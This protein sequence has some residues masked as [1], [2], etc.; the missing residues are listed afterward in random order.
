MVCGKEFYGTAEYICVKFG[1]GDAERLVP[2]VKC[3][4]QSHGD[5]FKEPGLDRQK[6][7]VTGKDAVLAEQLATGRLLLPSNLMGI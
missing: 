4:K 2:V 3:G 1:D 6:A 7:D 5:T